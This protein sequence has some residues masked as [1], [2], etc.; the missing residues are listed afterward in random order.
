MS[1]GTGCHDCDRCQWTARRRSDLDRLRRR[2]G[3]G[4]AD[5]LAGVLISQHRQVVAVT[6]QTN[7]I[8]RELN[9][10]TKSLSASNETAGAAI[11]PPAGQCGT[12][13]CGIDD[14][15]D[16]DCGGL[17]AE[18]EAATNLLKTFDAQLAQTKQMKALRYQVMDATGEYV[19]ENGLDQQQRELEAAVDKANTVAGRAIRKWFFGD[20]KTRWCPS[21]PEH[22]LCKR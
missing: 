9:R 15:N 20:C 8:T 5:V 13:S 10:L 3:G 12:G 1:C 11:V 19:P 2:G 7:A 6:K 17:A 18:W 22:P 4:E 16:A 21:N 14:G